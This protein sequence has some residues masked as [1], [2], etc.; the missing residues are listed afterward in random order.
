MTL[1][2]K[3]NGGKVSQTPT[4]SS[5]TAIQLKRWS[6][7]ELVAI[8][9]FTCGIG[10]LY[11]AYLQYEALKKAN[12]EAMDPMVAIVLEI[13][14]YIVTGGL[15]TLA[16]EYTQL[17]H[18]VTLGERTN[19]AGRNHNLMLIAM[20]ANVASLLSVWGSWTGFLAI[21]AFAFNIYAIWSIQ[22]E[23]EL[24]TVPA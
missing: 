5:S 17:K 24:Y 2:T 4:L 21:T 15:L 20:G 1:L 22:K 6:P 11:V 16:I 7:L 19:Q 18:L 3:T 13:V 12:P 9:V 14:G 8:T 10:G 23:L